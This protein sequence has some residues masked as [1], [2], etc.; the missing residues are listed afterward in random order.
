MPRARHEEREDGDPSAASFHQKVDLG[1]PTH[2]IKTRLFCR[3]GFRDST[4]VP[5]HSPETHP[6]PLLHISPTL[7]P[8]LPSRLSRPKPRSVP[9]NTKLTLVLPLLPRVR[10]RQRRWWVP[11]PTPPP[12]RESPKGTRQKF[13]GAPR[14]HRRHCRHRSTRTNPLSSKRSEQPTFS[15]SCASLSPQNL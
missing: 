8:A 3:T 9:S 13:P 11:S 15:V 12:R 1:V 2:P 14:S 5:G 7:H 4:F 6:T 10:V